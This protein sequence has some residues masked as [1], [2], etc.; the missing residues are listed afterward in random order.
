MKLILT[1]TAILYVLFFI[2]TACEKRQERLA[3]DR[4]LL[5]SYQEQ[6]LI[7]AKEKLERERFMAKITKDEMEHMKLS[8]EHS[9]KEISKIQAEIYKLKSNR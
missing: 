5:P 3:R 1:L 2:P 4:A 9:L 7:D 8:Y 6:E